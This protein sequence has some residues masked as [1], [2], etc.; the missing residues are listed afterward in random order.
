MPE[1][2]GNMEI[3]EVFRYGGTF[4]EGRLTNLTTDVGR[5]AMKGKIILLERR[6]PTTYHHLF[7]SK[8]VP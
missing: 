2:M 1:L 3:W 8:K 5:N 7:T 4:F 6:I